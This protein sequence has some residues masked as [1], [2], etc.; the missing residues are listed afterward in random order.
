MNICLDPVLKQ[1]LMQAVA[2]R[3]ADDKEMPDMALT[4]LWQNESGEACQS[5]SVRVGGRGA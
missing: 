4:F 5:F 2:F 3:M 1:V